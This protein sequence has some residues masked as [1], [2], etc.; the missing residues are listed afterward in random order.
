MRS[1]FLSNGAL[2]F[3]QEMDKAIRRCIMLLPPTPPS[4]MR[5]GKLRIRDIH[6][7]HTVTGA[8]PSTSS[9]RKTFSSH[10]LP[11]ARSKTTRCPSAA[12]QRSM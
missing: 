7:P 1:S 12:S 4:R 11:S 3:M 8:P 6:I 5:P 2:I 10:G 9:R